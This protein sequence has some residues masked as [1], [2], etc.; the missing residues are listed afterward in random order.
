MPKPILP[1][2]KRKNEYGANAEADYR[3]RQAEAHKIIMKKTKL[4]DILQSGTSMG[5]LARTAYS[6]TPTASGG[7]LTLKNLEKAY[8]HLTSKKYLKSVEQAQRARAMATAV[9]NR[10]LF[11]GV[12]NT[13]EFINLTNSVGF[14][15][16]IITNSEMY[17]KLEPIAKQVK[18][19]WKAWKLDYIKTAKIPE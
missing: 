17:R 6:G 7:T 5:G 18:K 4:D 9:I 16:V 1:A 19:E 3:E 12:I 13:F 11:L 2:G 14:N 8:K 15:G 10:A